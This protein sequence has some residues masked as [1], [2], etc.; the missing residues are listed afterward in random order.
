[1]QA[2]AEEEEEKDGET[3][4]IANSNKCSICGM[5]LNQIFVRNCKILKEA[6]KEWS[7]WDLKEVW[8]TFLPL[9][10]T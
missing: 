4:N 2:K 7:T 5:K 9:E 10:I 1:M 8:V 3:A 6:P